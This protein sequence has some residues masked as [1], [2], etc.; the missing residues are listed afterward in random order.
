MPWAA[1]MARQPCSLR[2]SPAGFKGPE[3]SYLA[4]KKKQEGRHGKR[5]A[6]R[7]AWEKYQARCPQPLLS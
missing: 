7:P 1:S 4:W 2:Y 6:L 3:N 5:M